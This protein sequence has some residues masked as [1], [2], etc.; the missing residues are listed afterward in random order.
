[1]KL[2]KYYHKYSFSVVSLIIFIGIGLS[3]LFSYLELIF[4]SNLILA[5][6][7]FLASI[8][9]VRLNDSHL[10]NYSEYKEKIALYNSIY[11]SLK[12]SESS[13]LATMITKS[14]NEFFESK[15]VKHLLEQK[16]IRKEKIERLLNTINEL[17][18]KAKLVIKSNK[19]D[20]NKLVF[21]I[22]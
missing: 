9:Y 15:R 11:L 20:N 18:E 21:L 1:M 19:I 10:D 17:Q 8:L 4:L 3:I 14:I 12:L 13:Y 16:V 7:I 6:F 22:Y 2:F 5:M